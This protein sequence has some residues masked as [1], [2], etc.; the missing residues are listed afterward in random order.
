M[1][2][3]VQFFGDKE[4]AFLLDP[5]MILELERLTRSGIGAISRRFFAGDFS[6]PELTETIRLAL[7][8][9]GMD[10]EDAATLVSVYAERLS[11][12]DLYGKALPI[13]ENL[14]FGSV[15][16]IAQKDDADAEA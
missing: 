11:V 6:Y 2:E 3:H 1:R 8:G 4:H 10:P 16:S 15:Q 12:T 7:I 14:M 9:G 13:I 5:G